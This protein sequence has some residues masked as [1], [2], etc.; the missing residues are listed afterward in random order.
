[1]GRSRGEDYAAATAGH[2]TL[3][4]LT[5]YIDCEGTIATVSGQSTKPWEPRARAHVW[6][7][8]LVSHEE[9]RAV[10]V[11]G[12]ATERDVEAGRTSHLCKNGNELADT[13]AKKG[14]DTH[15]PAF[16]VAKTVVACASLA[17]QAARWAAEAHV[18]LRFRGGTT[19]GLLRLDHGYGRRERDSSARR[20]QHRRRARCATGFLPSFPHVSRKTVTS[21]LALSEGTACFWDECRALDNAIIFCAKC[22]VVYCKRADALC[23]RCSEFPGGQSVAAAQIEVW[24]FSKQ[25][26]PWLD[27]RA[28]SSSHSGRGYY[29]GGTVGILRG[30]SGQNGHGA[31]HTQ[32]ATG[33]PSGSGS[34]TLGDA[35]ERLSTTK[36]SRCSV[37]T[38]GG[39]SCGRRMGSTISWSQSSPSRPVVCAPTR[40]TDLTTQVGSYCLI[41]HGPSETSALCVQWV[42]MGLPAPKA[43]QSPTTFGTRGIGAF[44]HWQGDAA[45]AYVGRNGLGGNVVPLCV[46]RVMRRA[47]RLG[48]SRARLRRGGGMGPRRGGF[49][50]RRAKRRAAWLAFCRRSTTVSFSHSDC[51]VSS[52]KSHKERE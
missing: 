16:R 41:Q 17:M 8:L 10:K 29:L 7:R 12:H 46:R 30:W 52:H 51:R 34:G 14:A 26:L 39:R 50:T 1:M 2:F 6:N 31:H 27:S 25:T 11:K 36:T 20:L 19:P 5:L 4:P 47:L 22:G 13:F 42:A 48:S 49:G 15:K 32:K 37:S 23:R 43:R 45:A 9:V 33:G 28:R 3:D 40:Q 35:S 38:S 21:T 24:A 18:L 44:P